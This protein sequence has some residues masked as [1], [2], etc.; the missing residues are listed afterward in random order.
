ML[1]ELAGGTLTTWKASNSYAINATIV[2]PKGN[3]QRVSTAGTSGGLQP[4][5]NTTVGGTTSDNGVTWSNAGPAI[6][7]GL[8]FLNNSV[9][10]NMDF[11]PA[12]EFSR[13]ETI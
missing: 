8:T 10:R 9:L 11:V 13:D 4:S 6:G 12:S 5:F 3:L 1:V 2:D 7:P